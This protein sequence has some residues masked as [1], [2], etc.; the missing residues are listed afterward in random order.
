[1]S[2]KAMDILVSETLPEYLFRMYLQNSAT[3]TAVQ[4]QTL[5]WLWLLVAFASV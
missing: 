5:H 1:M 3:T 2:G 4:N